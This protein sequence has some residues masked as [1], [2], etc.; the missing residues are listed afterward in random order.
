MDAIIF[1]L[2]GTLWDSRKSVASAWTAVVA[3]AQC[4]RKRVTEEDLSGMM[5]LQIQQIADILFE[6]LDSAE[7]TELMRVCCEREHAEILESGG[8]LYDKLE[9]TLSEL[10]KRYRL[11]IVSNCQEGYIESFYAYHGTE[12]YFEDFE[13]P[14]RTGL[15]K[16]K[17][18]KL[19]M[20]RN[21]LESPVYVGDTMGDMEAARFAGIPFVYAAYGFGEVSDYAHKI[22]KIEELMK[23]F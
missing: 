3:D 15:S 1:D 17:N 16:G 4:A 19:L 8:V 23:I 5:G 20:E 2:D 9:E 6:D 12:K 14:G 11:F 18:I 7:R 22:E 13:N 10:K 21:K